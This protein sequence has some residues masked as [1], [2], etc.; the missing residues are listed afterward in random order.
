MRER[1]ILFSA[2][3]VRAILDGRKTVTR[4]LLKP[5]PVIDGS[6]GYGGE[7]A[8]KWI[9]KS[10]EAGYCHT[11]ADALAKL[12]VV[13]PVYGVIGDRLWVRETWRPEERVADR[14]DGI[15][16]RADDAFVPIENAAQAAEQW[17]VAANN[18][19]TDRW[20]SPRFM[21]RW[22]SRIDLEVV[23]D[24]RVERL[25]A[26]TEEDADAEG[27]G[28]DT[29]ARAFPDF[30]WSP[31]A[32]DGSKTIVECFAE[33]WDA[34]NGKRAPW[35]SNPWLRRVEFRKVRP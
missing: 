11:N 10:L 19:H 34:I 4:R 5:Q 7:P 13:K 29:P 14:V 26:I 8:W 27:F 3:M 6:F 31:G 21:P 9:S 33:L 24:E 18:D 16:Y 23:V 2:P 20:R 12:A 35:K 32:L 1:P 28:G 22:A 30:P 15:R 25:Q 17:V